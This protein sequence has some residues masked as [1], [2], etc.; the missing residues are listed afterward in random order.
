MEESRGGADGGAGASPGLSLRRPPGGRGVGAASFLLLPHLHDVRA[1]LRRRY[2]R[3]RRVL[4]LGG[5]LV[6][7]L[8]FLDQRRCISEGWGWG[9]GTQRGRGLRGPL[10][11]DL[12]FVYGWG[13]PRQACSFRSAGA[14]FSGL[15]RTWLCAW[16]SV[17]HRW[18]WGASCLPSP[19]PSSMETWHC[20]RTPP[21]DAL[22]SPPPHGHGQPPT[23]G[24][25]Q[26]G[27]GSVALSPVSDRRSTLLWRPWWI[28]PQTPRG[29]SPRPGW[30][31]V[32]W[33]ENAKGIC[34]LRAPR[35][36]RE[37][38]P[39]QNPE[40]VLATDGVGRLPSRSAC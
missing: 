36:H 30:L 26:A 11:M 21:P 31:R 17:R 1:L 38:K 14:P 8:L 28:L 5:R 2:V 18:G 35:R 23:P 25:S 27:C 22:P 24:A 10:A 12:D 19:L 4:P 29:G 16:V 3:H 37:P 7:H 34:L 6:L 33:N 40:K 13:R 32:P 39:S 9:G 20:P 15:L